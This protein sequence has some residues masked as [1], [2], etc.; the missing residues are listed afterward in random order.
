MRKIILADE[1][2]VPGIVSRI[3]KEHFREIF[4]REWKKV[5]DESPLLLPD[6]KILLLEHLCECVAWVCFTES[7]Y[8]VKFRGFTVN[9]A[10]R[11]RGLGGL[12][13]GE[14]ENIAI[15][16][17]DSLLRTGGKPEDIRLMYL[18]SLVY[19]EPKAAGEEKI[20]HFQ[21]GAYLKSRG[22]TAHEYSKNGLI[23][24]ETA[25]IEAYGKRNAEA[26]GRLKVFRKCVVDGGVSLNEE[27][28]KELAR[29]NAREREV[30]GRGL[31]WKLGHYGKTGR[32][33]YRFDLC[34]ICADIGSSEE[35][36]GNCRK[37]YIYRTCREPFREPGRFKEDYLVS[38]AYFQAVREF[39][40]KI[41]TGRG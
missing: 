34:P 39:L 13:F 37:C 2:R 40:E 18:D 5:Y 27:A 15:R 21:F 19:P 31:A 28:K 10:T 35:E 23:P 11:G 8:R 12:L 38:C 30:V 14:L 3:K 9:P 20:F 32:V 7:V 16:R 1:N 26:A 6:E 29:M 36:S 25:A 4:G 24:E 22:F 41:R 33:S 17:H